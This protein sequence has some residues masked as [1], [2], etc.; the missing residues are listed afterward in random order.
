MC[1]QISATYL[2]I[3]EML[4]YMLASP[5]EPFVTEEI[6]IEKDAGSTKIAKCAAMCTFQTHFAKHLL[7]LRQS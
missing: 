1:P 5:E 4:T 3:L 7:L 6:T 2:H